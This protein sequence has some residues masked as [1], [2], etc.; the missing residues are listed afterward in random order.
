VPY[1]AAIVLCLASVAV[2]PAAG[3]RSTRAATTP[4][5]LIRNAGAEG[6]T[7]DSV[8]GKVHVNAWTVAHADQ[9]TAVAYGV[10][11]FPDQNSPGPLHRGDNF[12]A[13]GPDGTSA[14]GTQIVSLSDYRTM[15]SAG[16]AA[17][18]LSGWLGG[19][20]SQRDAATLSVTWRN[21]AGDAVGA[22]TKIGPVSAA[23]RQD[24]TGMLRRHAS[25]AV[26]V[27]ARSVLVKLHMG[28][29]DGTYN[30]GYADNLSLTITHK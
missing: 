19:Y 13:G 22:V 10:P 4:V 1:S 29:A 3:A 14:N 15:I 24:V 2:A 21:G 16:N 20:S 6:A 26:P 7:P 12:F 9:F 27:K 5:N 25:G 30:D 28:R 11:A 8:G 18:D 17:F 23:A